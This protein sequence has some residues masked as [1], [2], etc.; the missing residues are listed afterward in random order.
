MHIEFSTL[1]SPP[2]VVGYLYLA[3]VCYVHFRGQVRLRFGRQLTEHSGLFSPYN[4]LMYAFS[5]APRKPILDVDDFPALAPLRENWKTIRDEALALQGAG[6][7]EYTEAHNDLAFVAFKKRGWKRFYL[8]WYHDFLPSA[9]ELCP[10]TVE[11]V[12]SIPCINAAAFTVLPPGKKLGKHRDPFASSLRYHLGLS[13]PNSD[14][15]TIWIDGQAYSWRDGEDIVFDETYVHWAENETEQ[16][17]I[18]FF[19]DFTRPLHTP[20]MR[21]FVR[22]MNRYGFRITRSHNRVGEARGALNY[23]TP[24]VFAIKYFFI[25]LKSRHRRVYYAGKYAL[26]AALG[27]AIFVRPLLTP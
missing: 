6:E 27:Y 13:T 7:I 3:C 4:V 10:R 22:L 14:K 23:L 1:A 18:I 19:A 24:M 2:F 20:F 12:R 11:L 5:A 26:G 21:A 9:E 17:R 15:C 8:K 16:T 25:G